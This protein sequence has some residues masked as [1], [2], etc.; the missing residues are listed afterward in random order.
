MTAPGGS[1]FFS[2]SQ[3]RAKK[4]I[5]AEADSAMVE[6]IKGTAPTNAVEYERQQELLK[7][8]R[9]KRS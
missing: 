1:N 9:K 5:E 7:I 3:R 6:N 4:D 2:K 8:V